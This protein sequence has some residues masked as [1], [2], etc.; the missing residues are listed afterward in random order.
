METARR[1]AQEAGRWLL[2]AG[3]VLGFGQSRADAASFMNVVNGVWSTGVATGGGQLSQT[4]SNVD[5]HYTLIKTPAGC[6]GISCTNDVAGPFGPNTYVVLNPGNGVYPFNGAWTPND[7]NSLWIGPRSDQ[8]NP[9]VTGTTFPYVNI[10]ASSTD[11][12]VYRLVF[13]LGALGLDPAT[14]LIQLAWL[15]DNADN[16]GGPLEQSHIRLCAISNPTDPVCAAGLVPNSTN[17]GQSAVSLTPVTIQ[18]NG[19]SVVFGSGLMAL[20][21]VVYNSPIASGLNPSGMRV[22]ILSANAD[23]VSIPEPASLL[24]ISAGF[25]MGGVAFRR[26]RS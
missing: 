8:T 5:P 23:L 7:S 26:R 11:F 22:H 14:A 20:D 1:K 21:F 6:S 15:S 12:Y 10:Y 17:L 25:L 3:L 24:L 16:G 18:H 4:T 2:L 13:N 9:T 19:T